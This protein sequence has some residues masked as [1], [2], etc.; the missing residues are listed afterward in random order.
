MIGSA[1]RDSRNTYERELAGSE[2]NLGDFFSHKSKAFRDF[3]FILDAMKQ[4][5]P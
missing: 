4:H 3:R 1:L 5:A 2:E